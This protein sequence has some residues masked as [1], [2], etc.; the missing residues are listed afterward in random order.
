M[1]DEFL[2]GSE[3]AIVEEELAREEV[4]KFVVEKWFVLQ[5]KNIVLPESLLYNG[6]L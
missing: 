6:N 2:I 4:F 3:A 1:L 5:T